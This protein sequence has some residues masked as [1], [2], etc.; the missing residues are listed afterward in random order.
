MRPLLTRLALAFGLALPLAALPVAH[1]QSPADQAEQVRLG[2]EM[3]RLA[4]RNA[5]RG[6]DEAYRE[7]LV[8]EARGVVVNQPDHVLGADAAVALGDISAAYDRLKRSTKPRTTEDVA[9]RIAAIEEAFGSVTIVVEPKYVGGADLTVAQM[10]FA[11]D[12]RNAITKAQGAMIEAR[13]YQGLLPYGDYTVGPRSFTLTREGGPVTVTLAAA[14]G[15]QRE[16]GVAFVGPRIDLGPAFTAAGAPGTPDGT[17]PGSFSGAGLRGGVG[18]QLGT[19]SGFGGLVQVGYHG[20]FGGKPETIDAF[21]TDATGLQ[22]GY[23]WL[24]G[25]FRK[26]GLDLAVGPV[27]GVGVAKATGVA[28]EG[29]GPS[30]LDYQTMSGSIVTTGGSVAGSYLFLDLGSLKGG[31]GLQAGAQSDGS[32]LY[33]WGQLGLTLAPARRDG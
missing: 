19:H 16:K 1:A 32:R 33:P 6:V 22:L 25:T 21:E 15:V 20:M 18:V 28:T 26:G 17:Q 29:G 5:W 23:G 14:D 12:Q 9:Q 30:D 11:A 3:R 4:K 24:A 2:E 8:L 10:P 7:M 27:L 31:V 13:G